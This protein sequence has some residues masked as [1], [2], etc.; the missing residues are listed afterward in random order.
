M[1]SLHAC[2]LR[3]PLKWNILGL[4]EWLWT[5]NCNESKDDDS[6]GHESWWLHFVGVCAPISAE[7]NVLTLVVNVYTWKVSQDTEN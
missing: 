7:A 2:L 4:N 1:R 5:Y 3:G 6:K